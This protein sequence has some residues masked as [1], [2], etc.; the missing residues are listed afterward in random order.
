VRFIAAVL[1]G[2]GKLNA[3]AR[4]V[5]FMQR[6]GVD[7]VC[8]GFL[9]IHAKMVLADLGSAQAQAYIGSE[10]LSC[11]SL[12]DNRECGIIVTE[13]A[14]L[15][16]LGAVFQSDWAQPSVAVAPDPTPLTA[17]PGNGPAQ[18]RARIAQRSAGAAK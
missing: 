3:N 7:A 16:R 8:K 15:R 13:P 17:C 4:G 2:E 1:A 11:V 6:G 9:Y 14:I 18:A 5:T 10:N 12:G